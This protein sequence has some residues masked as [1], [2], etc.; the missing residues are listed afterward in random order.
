MVNYIDGDRALIHLMSESK[1]LRFLNLV[2]N[3]LPN[4][5]NQD[6]MHQKMY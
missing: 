4:F 2:I 1:K 3:T 5:F 6:I